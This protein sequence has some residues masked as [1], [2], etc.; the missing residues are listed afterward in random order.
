MESKS[1][2]P[3]CEERPWGGFW[4]FTHNEISTVKIIW[5][6]PKERNSLQLHHHR[7]ERWVVI[8]GPIKITI[9]DKE[10]VA[11]E[12]EMFFISRETKHRFTGLKDKG[13]ILEISYGNFDE[14][15][16]VRL[17]DDYGRK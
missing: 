13:K 3:Y 7:D 1:K 2:K 14:A 9:G 15:D 12:E 10:V 4:Q 8:K 5:V 11:N 6:K 16:N 17:E